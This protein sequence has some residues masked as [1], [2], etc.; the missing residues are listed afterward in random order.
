MFFRHLKIS[1]RNLL[2]QKMFTSINILGLA[3]G[4]A[5]SLLIGVFVWNELS[6]ETMHE[7]RDNIYR[8]AVQVGTQDDGMILAG[9][10]PALGPAAKDKLPEI[11]DYV[12]IQPQAGAVIKIGDQEYTENGFVYAD[13]S[14]FDFFTFN[15]IKQ[16]DGTPLSDPNDIMISSTT[17]KKYFGD[18]NPVGKMLDKDGQSLKVS[19]IFEEP[20]GNTMIKPS[21]IASR[22]SIEN[23]Y[24]G[25]IGWQSFG[26]EYLFLSLNKNIS[27]SELTKELTG[28]VE[29]NAPYIV[30]MIKLIPE[31]LT[32]IHLN[33]EA[34]GSF[35]NHGD[36]S[37]VSLFSVIAIFVLFI[38]S[39]NFIN[40]ST[41]R[42][43][44]RAK[45]VG[46]KKVLGAGRYQI[47]SQFLFEYLLVTF[48][49]LVIG[50]ILFLIFYPSLVEYLGLQPGINYLGSVEFYLLTVSIFLTVGILSGL[51]P[52]F[53]LT[54]FN[55]I[56]TVKNEVGKRRGLLDFRKGLVVVQFA[57]SILMIFGTIVVYEQLV[58]MKNYDIGMNMNNIVVLNYSPEK[59]ENVEMKYNTFRTRLLE[60]SDIKNVAGTFTLP[61]ISAFSR[62]SVRLEGKSEEE[63]KMLNFIGVDYDFLNTMDI[64]LADG[65]NFSKDYATD[66]TNAV[67][68][69]EAAVKE[70]GL[71]SPVG[72]HLMVP[73]KIK[74]DEEVSAAIIGVVKNFNLRSLRNDVEP[75]VL[76][77]DPQ[78][79]STI[80]VKIS[81]D[82]VSSTIAD[83]GNIWKDVF[84]NYEFKYSFLRDNYESLYQSE[85]KITFIFTI[86]AFLA[87]Y[88]AAMGLFGL[89]AF[90]AEQRKKEI[91]IRKVLGSSINGVISLL[92]RDYLILVIIASLIS[93]PVSYYLMDTWLEGFAYRTNIGWMVYL[94]SIIIALFIALGT[95][96]IQAYRAATLNPVKSIRYE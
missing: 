86:F 80:A 47:A 55:P 9:V 23:N 21:L 14:I 2:K 67:I 54:K 62:S 89:S 35:E 26:S 4:F 44:R 39:L 64:K 91:G 79:F 94:S 63:T 41:A 43:F 52:A 81:G 68:L 42:S 85:E 46:I 36:K 83:I 92:T 74:S 3:I 73:S 77:I 18:E 61:G 25:A 27:S 17:A 49:A 66:K 19:G 96:S 48:F 15:I 59:D 12:R 28:V 20:V 90:S 8:I 32:D 78:R 71:T 31:K 50:L 22:K 57:V 24:A 76:T 1:L 56:K 58:Y 33:S 40:L 5:G 34:I 75:I 51:Y 53:Y 70:F 29:E 65:R 45:E 87:I 11:Y 88:I 30:Q 16:I 69:N 72:M 7:N 82:N 10:M 6:Y 60:S 38:A 84:P 37:Y 95:V 13:E 93:L